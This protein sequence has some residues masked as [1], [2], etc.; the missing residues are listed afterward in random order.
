MVADLAGCLIETNYD[1]EQK[2][3]GS[4]KTDVRGE[5]PINQT[6]ETCVPQSVGSAQNRIINTLTPE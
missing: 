2:F 5:Q 4:K 6:P 3:K 1:R